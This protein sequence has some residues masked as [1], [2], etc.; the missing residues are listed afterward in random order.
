MLQQGDLAA[1]PP[2]P[3]TD[4]PITKAA[5]QQLTVL[6]GTRRG[7]FGLDAS[8]WLARAVR[9]NFND[10]APGCQFANP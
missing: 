5:A 9:G 7:A 2:P 1:Q 3:P 8:D 4:K 6:G 10:A